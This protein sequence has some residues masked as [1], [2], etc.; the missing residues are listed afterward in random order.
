MA[1]TLEI[2]DLAV[3][4][5]V[6]LS[7]L[8]DSNRRESAPPTPFSFPLTDAEI[9]EIYWLLDGYAYDPFGEARGR[10]E[11]TEA[12]LRDLGR[13]LLETVFRSGEKRRRRS[14]PA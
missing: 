5:Q 1:D 7:I 11:V 4:G 13:M 14:W 9:H 2:L 10:A 3:S 8:D 6:Q 12:G